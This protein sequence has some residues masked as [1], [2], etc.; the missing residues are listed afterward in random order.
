[1]TSSIHCEDKFGS[2]SPVPPIY[3][4]LNEHVII[5]L[6]NEHSF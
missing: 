2:G 5:R 6:S 4:K 3:S 1:M